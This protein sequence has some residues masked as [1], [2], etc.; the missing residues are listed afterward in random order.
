MAKD[1]GQDLT[2]FEDGPGMIS[3]RY[4]LAHKFSQGNPKTL[5]EK[6]EAAIIRKD[7]PDHIGG[8]Y[9]ITQK[10]IHNLDKFEELDQKEQERVIGR[11]KGHGSIKLKPKPEDAHIA[12]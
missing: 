4:L 6:E 12:R 10:W 8:S 9:A 5:E 3:R 1:F 7:D 11:T 2:G